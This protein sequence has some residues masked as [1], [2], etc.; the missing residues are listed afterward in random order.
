MSCI[1]VAR[2]GDIEDIEGSH[3]GA[4]TEDLGIIQLPILPIEKFRASS[5]VFHNGAILLCG[6]KS[7]WK[8]CL[9]LDHGTWKEHSTLNQERVDH[10]AVTTQTATFL[11]GGLYSEKT[12]EYLP[13]GSTTWLMGKTEI[14]RRFG[15]G[16][17]IAV[18][19]DQ[20]I[21]LIGGL[22]TEKRIL[23]F[24][25]KYHTFK[26]MP[27]QLNLER[28]GLKCAFVPNTKK[29]MITGGWIRTAGGFSFFNSTEIL[30]I[31]D[32]SVTM[33]SPMNSKRSG[34]GMGV[35]T[36]NGEDRLA[37]FG[38][39]FGMF[40]MVDVSLVQPDSVE[41]YNTQKNEWEI[42]NFKLNQGIE[43]FGFLTVKLSDIISSI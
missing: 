15:I 25:V 43:N 10:S 42:A 34:H 2:G 23:S 38:G 39:Y 28:F 13:K 4:I 22:G 21:L 12:Y 26:E 1:V 35:L 5:M 27:Y 19:S 30:D 40:D 7:N 8:K 16:C 29:V 14:P 33:A 9:Q 31:E 6:G 36:I 11:F 32:G 41:L 24:N 17:A 37:V 18:K 3:V 20:E